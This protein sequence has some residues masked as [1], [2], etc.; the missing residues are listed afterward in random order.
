MYV[1]NLYNIEYEPQKTKL[2]KAFIKMRILVKA[3]K[4]AKMNG[5]FRRGEWW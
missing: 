2:R 1:L 4:I 5:A 3:L